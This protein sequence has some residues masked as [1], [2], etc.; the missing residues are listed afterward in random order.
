MQS[1]AI[2]L[3]MDLSYKK[4]TNAICHVLFRQRVDLYQLIFKSLLFV[5]SKTWP[6]VTHTHTCLYVT[7]ILSIFH[8]LSRIFLHLIRVSYVQ[9]VTAVNL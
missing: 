6:R 4:Q 9:Y 1:Y 3:E 2:Y 5:L 7:R 8:M